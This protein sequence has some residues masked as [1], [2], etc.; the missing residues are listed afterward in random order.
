[1]PDW[2]A[3]VREHLPPLHVTPEREGEIV[4]E[5]ALQLEQAAGDAEAAGASA[6]EALRQA[7]RQL[8]GW[9]R[10][11]REIN[12]E[13]RSAPAP[14]SRAGWFAG[15][16]GDIRYALRFLRRNPG[17]AAIATLTLAFGIGGNTAIFT[18]VDAIALRSLPY[19]QA[20]RLM[21]IETRKAGQPEVEP[22]TSA[23]DF[24]DLR[25]GARS[26][27][28]MAG[29]SPIWSVVLTGRGAAERLETLYVSASF[30]PLLGVKP[31][32]GR[33]FTPR[34]DAG[35]PVPVA[36]LSYALWQRQFAGRSDVL[37]QTLALDVGTYT[38]IGVMPE[39][40]R[41]AGEP[42]AGTAA[43]IDLWLPLAS[44]QLARSARS[45]RFLKVVGRLTDGTSPGQAREEIG[46]LGAALSQEYPSTNRGFTYG[47]QPLGE[48]ASGRYRVAMLLLLG[49]VGFV[50]LMACANVANLL[51]GRAAARQREIGVRVALGASRFRLLR[52]L[53]TEGAVLAAAGGALGL[54]AAQLALRF[55]IA[56][57]PEALVRTRPIHLD[58][59]ALAWTCATV[60]LCALLSGLPPA[61]RMVRGEIAGALREAGRGLTAGH[62]ALRSALVVVQVA[63]ALILLVGAGLLIRSF[64]RLLDVDPGFDPH[65]LITVTTLLPG[66]VR[67]PA[68]AT[69]IWRRIA[70]NV[71]STPG[72]VSVA[73]VS[74]LPL[75]GSNLGTWLYREGHIV[76]G[77]PGFDTEY[78]V[79]TP[80]Y[81]ATMRIPL[82]SGRL[83]D[84]HDEVN[85]ACCALI[86][87]AAARRIFAGEDPVGRRIKLGSPA[88][89]TP[90]VT[91]VGVIGNVRHVGLDVDPR[92]EVYRPYA[93]NPLGNPVLVIRT[94]VDPE[95]LAAVLAAKVRVDPTMPAYNLYP[96]Q[97]LVDRST[98]ERR[99]VML[100]LSGFALAAMLLA[101]VGV[102]GTVAQAVTRRS[103]EIGVRIAL[104][105]SPASALLLVF[106]EGIRLMAAGLAIGTVAAAALTRLMRNLLF[107]VRPLDAASFLAAALVLAGTAML[108]C[109]VPARRAT[110]VDPLAILREE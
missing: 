104:G 66:S 110:R 33:S 11:A 74:R 54:A 91:I 109:Y 9:E 100:L 95:G 73:A 49:T 86:N 45:L 6:A 81:F 69:G 64:Q 18:M 99:F 101:A 61:W 32:L 15:W 14:E 7:E 50:L 53:L 108:A 67:T 89:G 1:M 17:F 79:A 31:L 93:F 30:F 10:L 2:R 82:R 55:L 26:L 20:D 23:L 83:F 35:A 98:V 13:E 72:V 47:V 22:W 48:Q 85:P 51:L 27:S 80:G 38:V 5:L 94:A 106:R 25:Q 92:P 75:M 42:V 3:Y 24:A 71:A 8:G 4:A 87:E 107:E 84:E 65:R 46:R 16:G 102:Y 56:R 105:A 76:P 21:A 12:A 58:A 29:V 34:E 90:W 103:R 40:F 96:M 43:R 78:R 59:R 63:A 19:R 39:N 70:E 60:L 37:G 41:Y 97:A 52:Q 88:A 57:G 28:A 77:E 36:I 44:N 68:Q 62:R